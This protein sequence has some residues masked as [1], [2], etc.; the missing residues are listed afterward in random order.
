MCGT[1]GQ[2][3]ST[4]GVRQATGTFTGKRA[5]QG[6]VLGAP[7]KAGDVISQRYTVKDVVGSGPFGFVLRARDSRTETE[8]AIKLI[9]P[10][11][12]QT[13]EER[14]LFSERFSALR[15]LSHSNVARIYEDGEDQGWPF[16]VTQYV[17]GVSLR[18]ILEL[19]AERAQPFTPG[20]LE[21]ILT[22][23]A[24][25]LE[26]AQWLSPHADL[27]PEN[28]LVLPDLVK[29]SDFGLGLALPRVPFVQALKQRGAE[30]YLAP[31]HFAGAE[32]DQRA[33]V[34]SL[35]V[36]VGEM[37]SGKVPDGSIPELSLH[38]PSLPR[39]IDRVYRKALHPDPGAR[40]YSARELVQELSESL[41]NGAGLP[42]PEGMD[43]SFEAARDAPEAVSRA[44]AMSLLEGVESLPS[45]EPAEDPTELTQPMALDEQAL[46]G[47]G[48]AAAEP[49]N[50]G[51][52]SEPRRER[53]R[54]A[55]RPKL[56]MAAWAA[57]ACAAGVIVGIA[58]GYW[59]A[60]LS[61]RDPNLPA[62]E[63]AS[64]S[65]PTP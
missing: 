34:Y 58:S 21:P 42:D 63:A 15:R 7:Y 59:F 35:A 62:P 23:I 8:V 20:E 53:S 18:K 64:A 32:V 45:E 12:L 2:K 56:R 17:E 55:W 9:H 29:V 43:D 5:A 4:G 50:G 54:G 46:A 28:V 38:N 40:F 22:Q 19:R 57:G 33:D 31:E 11:F 30:R 26:A 13:A 61:A 16:F 51:Q 48:D 25:A 65:R 41:G 3:L 14:R 1:C 47:A 24:E 52:I 39:D 44:P 10:R 36:I 37:L 27:K 49:G 60:R 6:S